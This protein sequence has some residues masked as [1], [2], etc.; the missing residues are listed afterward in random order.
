MR[1]LRA[2]SLNADSLPHGDAATKD[3]VVLRHYG[4]LDRKS[5]SSF[6]LSNIKINV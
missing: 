5:V 6:S 1:G 2:T 3:L 4:K